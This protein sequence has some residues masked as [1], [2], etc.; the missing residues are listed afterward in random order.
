MGVLAASPLFLLLGVCKQLES[1]TI[2]VDLSLALG[3]GVSGSEKLAWLG[4]PTDC[5]FFKANFFEG[6][7]ICEALIIGDLVSFPC[8][9]DEAAIYASWLVY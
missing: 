4:T 1:M 7:S 8:L 9:L 3:K 6:V 2:E 5:D